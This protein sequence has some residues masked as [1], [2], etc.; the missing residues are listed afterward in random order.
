M[1]RRVA[2]VGTV[3]KRVRL[4][5]KRGNRYFG[6]S[7]GSYPILAGI[8]ASRKLEKDVIDVLV[9]DHGSRSVTGIPSPVD[10]NQCSAEELE[11]LPGIGKARARRIIQSRP[12]FR[13]EDL[14][15]ALDEPRLLDELRELFIFRES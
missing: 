15:A 10:M 13:F 2:P 14:E 6:R 5:E 11:A 4:E 1:I 3:L 8:A 7:L 9:T 12:Y